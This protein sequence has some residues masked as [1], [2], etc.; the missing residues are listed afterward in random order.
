MSRRS[1]RTHRII[2]NIEDLQE[3][4]GN[5]VN[6]LEWLAAKGYPTGNTGP[7]PTN[8]I[9]RPTEQ[10]ATSP[11]DLPAHKWK[12]LQH[13]ERDL[14]RIA[15]EITSI[16]TWTISTAKYDGPEPRPC[17]N[18]ECDR[19]ISMIGSDIPRHGRCPRCA[20]HHRRHHTEYPNKP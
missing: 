3:L 1:D 10:A 2:Q 17:I 11:D 20:Q 12:R 9:N 4:L 16:R 18:I 6:H 8:T 7:G 13:L 14:D 5:W 19:E 15:R